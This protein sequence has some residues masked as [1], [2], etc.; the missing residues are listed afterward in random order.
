MSIT[1][2]RTRWLGWDTGAY[3]IE[4]ASH[5]ETLG[6]DT[7][8]YNYST[9]SN[10]KQSNPDGSWVTMT[11]GHGYYFDDGTSDFDIVG[12]FSN[13]SNSCIYLHNGMRNLIKG[14]LCTGNYQYVIKTTATDTSNTITNNIVDGPSGIQGSAAM[15]S[16]LYWGSSIASG[17]SGSIVANP[18]YS[19][20]ITTSQTYVL[21]PLGD[22]SLQSGSPA[23]SV[24]F[25][26]LPWGQ[27]GVQ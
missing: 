15:S 3:Y 2:S 22:Y 17:D 8:R 27:M 14:N 11:Y 18:L 4:Y 21:P 23:F 26:E 20:P 10:G 24:G 1:S 9:N 19:G 5:T 12:N 6:R 13:L 25:Q 7:M 16:N